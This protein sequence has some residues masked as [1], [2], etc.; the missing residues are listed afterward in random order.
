MDVSAAKIS[1]A[2]LTG[3]DLPSARHIVGVVLTHVVKASGDN[4]GTGAFTSAPGREVGHTVFTGEMAR[5]KMYDDKDRHRETAGAEAKVRR[6]GTLC[7]VRAC[8]HRTEN[9]DSTKRTV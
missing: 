7:I 6:V 4:G 3:C 5:R 2:Y 1:V 8:V 9:D